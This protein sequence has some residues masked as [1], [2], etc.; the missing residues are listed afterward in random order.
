MEI[1]KANSYWKISGFKNV[2]YPKTQSY[3]GTHGVCFALKSSK[4]LSFPF[5]YLIAL[6]LPINS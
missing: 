1:K 5:K 4:E 2:N 3:K 6:A